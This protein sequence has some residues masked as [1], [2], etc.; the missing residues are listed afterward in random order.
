MINRNIPSNK[1]RDY[2]Q[3][4]PED[5]PKETL[6]IHRLSPD[7]VQELRRQLD[8]GR[9]DKTTTET[10]AAFKLGIQHAL[11]VLEQGFVSGQWD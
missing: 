5:T 7:M 10:Q 4:I 3:N 8:D 1:P 2:I 9:V 6:F 11:N